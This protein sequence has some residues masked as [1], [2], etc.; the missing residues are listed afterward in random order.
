MNIIKP[1]FNVNSV[2]QIAAI[3]ALNDKNLLQNQLNIIFF[4][5]IDLK[6]Y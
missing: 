1:P 3:A 5:P 2:A 6:K 4:G